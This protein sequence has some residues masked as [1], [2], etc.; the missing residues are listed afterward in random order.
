MAKMTKKDVS[1]QPAKPHADE[2]SNKGG[3]GKKAGAKSS[4]KK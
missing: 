4:K 3:M 1:A 2:H